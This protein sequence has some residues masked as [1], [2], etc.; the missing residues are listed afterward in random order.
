MNLYTYS[1]I[2][3]INNTMNSVKVWTIVEDSKITSHTLTHICKS[4]EHVC[5]ILNAKG[6]KLVDF[7]DAEDC[8]RTDLYMYSITCHWFESTKLDECGKSMK[9]T[10]IV[11]QFHFKKNEPIEFSYSNKDMLEIKKQDLKTFSDTHKIKKYKNSD[12]GI[13]QTITHIKRDRWTSML[14]T[15]HINSDGDEIESI[16]GYLDGETVEFIHD[17]I[18]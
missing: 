9:T 2:V 13:K 12:Q 14:I 5:E 1:H 4:F 7:N 10:Y 3:L 17:I 18:F 11:E 6:A 8:T 16:D 15:Y